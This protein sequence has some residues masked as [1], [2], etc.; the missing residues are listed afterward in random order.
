M[1]W[2]VSFFIAL[3]AAIAGGASAIFVA[4][5]ATRWF[6]VSD[7]EGG[8]GYA[9]IGFGL[10]GLGGGAVIGFVMSRQ[11]GG[12]T[13][14]F[15]EFFGAVGT[16]LGIVGLIWWYCWLV[17]DHAPTLDGEPLLLEVE[18]RS[19]HRE[20]AI[21]I[22]KGEG[23]AR[24]TDRRFYG[25]E[26]L[27]FQKRRLKETDEGWVVTAT[28]PLTTRRS[29]R[30]LAIKIGEKEENFLLPLRGKPKRADLEWS[31]WLPRRRTDGQ[32]PAFTLTY[33]YRAFS[34][35]KK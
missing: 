29:N 3:L 33:R 17:T 20:D 22:Q 18:I 14:F 15:R 2:I 26:R 28:V 25:G 24:L 13:H 35:K 21:E 10:L 23:T 6:H 9:V 27:V 7:R 32:P 12:G 5:K 8:R 34:R 4:E 30:L 11:L 19:P 1:N 16:T 31:I